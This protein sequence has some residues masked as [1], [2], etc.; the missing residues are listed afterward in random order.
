M[1]EQIDIGPRSIYCKTYK[2]VTKPIPK[3]DCLIE[4]IQL[5]VYTVEPPY[6]G[7]L[8]A[9]V[10]CPLFGG[11]RCIEVSYCFAYFDAQC[12]FCSVKTLS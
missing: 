3:N 1:I 6:N 12:M 8:G 9:N 11:V 10:Q 7:Q 2:A 4:I 5:H